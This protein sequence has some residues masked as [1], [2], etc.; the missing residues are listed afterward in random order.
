MTVKCTA[1]GNPFEAKKSDYNRGRARFC[2]LS[3]SA[4]H[5]NHLRSNK[6]LVKC[7]YCKK[8]LERKP[9]QVKRSQNQFCTKQCKRDFEYSGIEKF[10]RSGQ[11][12]RQH[13]AQKQ[14]LLD[15]HGVVCQFPKCQL[16]LYDDR[17]LV[18]M[19]HFETALDHSRTVL[20]CPYHHRLA[21][22]G[23]ITID[24]VSGMLVFLIVPTII[25]GPP[26]HF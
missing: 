13:L 25:Q 8:S 11:Q 10:K 5:G 1:C 9:S 7:S 4:K 14:M 3:C 16:N 18:D 26:E 22:R 24:K 21:D 12:R 17:R 15:R 6:I 19:H 2:S 20:L 23:H